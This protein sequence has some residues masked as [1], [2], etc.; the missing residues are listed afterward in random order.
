MSLDS[1]PDRR[2]PSCESNSTTS[3]TDS[4]R[5]TYPKT[6]SRS[7]Q[8]HAQQTDEGLPTASDTERPRPT[9]RHARGRGR[10]RAAG[11]VRIV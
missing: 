10:A 4:I 5:R 2:A 6:V 8:Q 7:Q 1:L 3:W 9:D 11:D